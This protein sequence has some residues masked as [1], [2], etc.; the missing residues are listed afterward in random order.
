MREE[1]N[2]QQQQSG[3]KDV[4][5]LHVSEIGYIVCTYGT[6]RFLHLQLHL[7]LQLQVGSMR[8]V[9]QIGLGASRVV[10]HRLATDVMQQQCS[11]DSDV[12][13]L[14]LQC[15]NRDGRFKDEWVFRSRQIHS[16]LATVRCLLV[17]RVIGT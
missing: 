17:N 16:T 2:K 7:Q 12:L 11:D 3:F 15:R 9:S 14:R 6:E 8:S 5:P 4:S 10:T 13:I 1:K